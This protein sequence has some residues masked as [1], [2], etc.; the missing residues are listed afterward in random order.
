MEIEFKNDFL[1][2]FS[3]IRKA[4]DT[5]VNDPEGDEVLLGYQRYDLKPDLIDLTLSALSLPYCHF[6]KLVHCTSIHD[7]SKEDYIKG[8]VYAMS[9]TTSS[10]SVCSAPTMNSHDAG[11][12]HSAVCQ[13]VYNFTSASH[14]VNYRRESSQIHAPGRASAE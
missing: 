6:E 10:D 13:S 3:D 14:L 5:L 2:D 9:A 11:T 8:D 4:I 1:H 12:N 7:I